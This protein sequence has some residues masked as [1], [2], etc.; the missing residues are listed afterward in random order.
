M[1]YFEVIFQ[2]FKNQKLTEL[3]WCRRETDTNE[4]V[5]KNV[6]LVYIIKYSKIW[7]G[8]SFKK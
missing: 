1:V 8:I 6:I 3:Y 7:N 2:K 5:L 4:M